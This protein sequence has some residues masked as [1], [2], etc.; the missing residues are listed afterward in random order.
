MDKKENE[1]KDKNKILDK[2]QIK[3]NNKS[4]EN[5]PES[6]I[7]KEEIKE[8]DVFDKNESIK[9]SGI[10]LGYELRL[11]FRVFIS[12]VFFIILIFLVKLLISLNTTNKEFYSEN[13]SSSYSVCLLENKYYEETCLS[14]NK[15]Y[16]SY[17]VDNIQYVFSYNTAYNYKVS[18]KY[19]YN[20]DAHLKIF[21]QDNDSQVLYEKDYILMDT[22]ELSDVNSVFTISDVVT[23]PFKQFNGFVNEYS[24]NYSILSNAEVTVNVNVN[25]KAVS[26]LTVPLGKQSFNI[27]KKDTN[28]NVSIDSHIK[29]K[30]KSSSTLYL[31]FVII[32]GFLF[33]LSIVYLLYYIFK[34]FNHN[35]YKKYQNEVNKILKNYDRIIVEVKDYGNL[36][37]DKTIVKVK[38]ILELIDVRDTLDKP[39]LHVKINS[40]K[41]GF[42]VEDKDK[43]YSFVMKSDY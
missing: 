23:I 24:N 40:I 37:N 33:I 11:I 2:K 7:E 42:Y 6:N 5:T 1:S 19:E 12:L 39:I 26:T 13:S 14:E 4:K 34:T 17:L 3:N 20:V 41:D 25:G 30:M 15:Q 22:K 38:S 10:Y 35:D 32:T 31:I 16:L 8:Y 21:S 36:F 9:R 29:N 43:I 27:V 18:K 28:Q